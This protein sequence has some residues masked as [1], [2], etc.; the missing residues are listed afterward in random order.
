M[1]LLGQIF[2]ASPNDGVSRENPDI[3]FS[4]CHRLEYDRP[5]FSSETLTFFLDGPALNLS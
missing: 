4:P 5:S 1:R 2:E 3:A